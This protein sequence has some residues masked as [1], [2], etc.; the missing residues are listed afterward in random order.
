[1]GVPKTSEG[2][3]KVEPN[4]SEIET[5]V[6]FVL[7]QTGSVLVTPKLAAYLTMVAGA[8]DFQQAWSFLRL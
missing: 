4:T 5:G 6:Y 3:E 1:M 8:K 7:M 2:V